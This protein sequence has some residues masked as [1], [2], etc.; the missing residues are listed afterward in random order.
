MGGDILGKIVKP[1]PQTNGPG[2]TPKRMALIEIFQHFN[3]GP[4]FNVL[5][6]RPI[7]WG[8]KRYGI[9]LFED[10]IIEIIYAWKRMNIFYWF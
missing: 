1:R 10:I 6:T 8:I 2:R 7:Y 4:D 5:S 3:N 9:L